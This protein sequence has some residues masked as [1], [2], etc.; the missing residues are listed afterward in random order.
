MLYVTTRGTQDA[1]TVHRTMSQDRGPDGGFFV[2]M[3]IP[4]LSQKEI[5]M[6]AHKG[7]SQNIAD[8]LNLFFG[9]KLSSWDVD[10]AIGRSVVSVHPAGHKI[11]IAELWRNIDGS[12]ER[13]ISSLAE[14]ITAGTKGSGK[15]SNWG[16][17]GIRLSVLIGIF[18]ELMKEG[19]ISKEKPVDVAVTTGS[20]AMPMALWYGRYMGLPIRTIVCGCNDNGAA[21]ELLHKGGLD[22]N[23]VA[24]RTTTPD[25]DFAVPPNLERLVHATL[26][27]DE[28]HRY[29]WCCTEG[30][31][32]ALSELDL[33][34]L[35][36][37]MFAAVVSKSRVET[38]IPSVYRTN[39]YVLD[40]YGALAYGALSDYRA[41]T[42][43]VGPA[44]VLTERSPLCSE[45]LVA[46]CMQI[47]SDELK[48][49]MDY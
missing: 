41:R 4:V 39:S 27:A 11:L 9:T 7:M 21:W 48:K 26:G 36:K 20:F 49:K 34:E 17:L 8:S 40:P 24:V 19:K 46:S 45:S 22:P 12:F 23:V 32:Y 25:A 13:V 15:V 42:G 31:N 38:I 44:L 30:R 6:L 37:G 1:Y 14:G 2:P 29:W 16:D 33:A 43:A 5:L 10:V 35:N 47:S 18:G 3:R 28:V